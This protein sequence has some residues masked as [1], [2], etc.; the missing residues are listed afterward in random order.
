MTTYLGLDV[1]AKK[2]VF[3][4]QDEGGQVVS[5]GDI[6][7]SRK[8]FEELL[9]KLG[10]EMGIKTGL[11]SGAQ[12]FWASEELSGLGFQ[13]YVINAAEVRA[14]SRRPTQKSDSRDAF[15]I[16]DGL[17]RDLY[18]SRIYV[19]S[20][21]V[22]TLRKLI[23]QRRFFVRGMTA[24]VNSTKSI[25]RGEGIKATDTLGTALAWKSF[26]DGCCDPF[27]RKLVKMHFRVW[28]QLADEVR[29]L[30]KQIKDLVVH[31]FGGLYQRMQT[32]PGVGPVV[33]STFLSVIADP[34]RFDESG[35]VVS[36]LGLSPSTW[37]SGDRVVHGRI[38][39]RGSSE[40]R[41]MLVEAAQQANR[42]TH[43]LHPY[44]ARMMSKHGY[45][46]AVVCVAQRLAR[47]M[48]RMW[49]QGEDFD[50]GKLNVAPVNRERKVKYH[51][52][53]KKTG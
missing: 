38:T 9:R 23:Q 28:K 36:Y 15:E 44:F 2:T 31:C 14:K 41:S 21:K 30:E 26:I 43:P 47:I 16:C 20:K 11:E 48:W 46:K 17:R 27:F 34:D 4:A 22:R 53:I 29:R 5:R 50:V 52:E 32:I 12:A 18:V 37:D 51:W 1:H 49:I 25:F 6:T 10:G 33:A 8:G 7:T 42:P 3:L 24:N 13:P 39:K 45:K 35:Q 19:P 40:G